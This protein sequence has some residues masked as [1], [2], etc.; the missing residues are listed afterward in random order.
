MWHL[1]NRFSIWNRI[2]IKLLTK[3]K[4]YSAV[5]LPSLLDACKNWTVY[6]WH[7]KWHNHFRLGF[8]KNITLHSNLSRGKYTWKQAITRAA[9]EPVWCVT[10]LID[11]LA[12]A[13]GEAAWSAILTCW[14][15]FNLLIHTGAPCLSPLFEKARCSIHYSRIRWMG[16]S[17][18]SH[19]QFHF[20]LHETLYFIH[21]S[22]LS[23]LHSIFHMKKNPLF[24]S[25]ERQ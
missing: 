24:S 1:E 22:F 7:T 3:L 21:V 23:V 11:Y 18:C 8:H 15:I 6:N 19:G 25:H 17:V 13:V 12:S 10:C 16:C 4:V 5:V 14:G 20:T 2:G 9:G